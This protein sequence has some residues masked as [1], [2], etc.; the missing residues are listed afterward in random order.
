[1]V[2]YPGYSTRTL[3]LIMDNLR[4]AHNGEGNHQAAIAWQYFKALGLSRPP[5]WNWDAFYFRP[6]A[7]RGRSP[8]QAA[9][10]ATPRAKPETY[11]CTCERDPECASCDQGWHGSCRWNCK[12]GRPVLQP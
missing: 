10:S 2:T 4:R 3:N 7:G 9:K 1:M 11:G 6:L 12:Y 8:R 5:S